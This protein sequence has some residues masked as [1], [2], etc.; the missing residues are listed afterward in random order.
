LTNLNPQD[1]VSTVKY[2]F[3]SIT[4][5]Y[6]LL[7]HLLS[8]GRDIYWR[9]FTAKRIPYNSRKILDLATGTGDLA[10]ALARRYPNVRIFGADFVLKMM[11][12]A[13]IKARR[14]K[15]AER[16]FFS[17]GDANMIPFPDSTFDAVTI[18][19]G[20]RNIND[21]F[22]AL[23]EMRRVLKP[24][25]KV[26]VLEMTLPRKGP[27]RLFFKFYLKNVIPLMG[28]LISGNWEAYRYLP[29]SIQN[30][31]APQEMTALFQSVRLV[32]I[33]SFPLTGGITYLH[34]GIKS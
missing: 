29:A 26:L 3:N 16:I 32:F 23:N 10:I 20:L 8:A 18:A 4:P 19:F 22:R 24:G 28:G 1:R 25:G 12:L 31:L 2:I 21:K 27:L 34:E 14:K 30:F 17:A 7:N 13:K 6:D 9:S 5:H 11:E 15:V 33:S